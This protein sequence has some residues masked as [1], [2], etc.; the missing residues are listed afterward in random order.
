MNTGPLKSY[1]IQARKD[2]IQAVTD[3]AAQLGITKNSIAPVQASSGSDKGMV[4]IA[5]AP[6]PASVVHARELVVAAIERDGFRAVIEQVAY[7]WF[8]RLVALRFMEVH[9]YLD[10]GLRILSDP[11]DG[12][13][14]EAVARL[15]DLELPTLDK[16]KAIELAMAGNQDEAL[17]RLILL[18][19]CQHLAKSMPWLFDTRLHDGVELGLGAEADK[20]QL[21][22]VES[23]FRTPKA[24]FFVDGR[25]I[26]S[27][28]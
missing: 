23:G 4:V 3:R 5:G 1:A 10:H 21:R 25:A 8:N 18:A 16:S 27:M 11:N 24:G 14:P 7:T 15:R 26:T 20:R 9:G 28:S 17:Y 13:V 6:F 2:F 22:V 19:Q 12:A